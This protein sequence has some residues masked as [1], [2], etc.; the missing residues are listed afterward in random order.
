MAKAAAVY[1]RQLDSVEAGRELGERVCAELGD[2]PPDALV[3]FASARFD[4]GALLAAVRDACHPAIMVGSSSAGEFT[5]DQRGEGTAVRAGDQCAGCPAT[6]ARA[7][8][9]RCALNTIALG[10]G[11]P[12]SGAVCP[13]PL[14]T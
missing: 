2:R 13:G 11:R 1:T 5:G 14:P 12:R 8:A 7:D 3:V 9:N 6:G 4:Y 10:T